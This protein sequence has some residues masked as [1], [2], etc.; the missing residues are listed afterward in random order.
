MHTSIFILIITSTQHYPAIIRPL[1]VLHRSR[2]RWRAVTCLVWLVA[3]LLTLPTVILIDL[4]TSHCDGLTESGSCSQ[5]CWNHSLS[6][7][8]GPAYDLQHRARF[9]PFWLWQLFSI[10]W[11]E[12]GNRGGTTVTSITFLVTCLAYGNNCLKPFLYTLLSKPYS[13]APGGPGEDGCSLGEAGA[14][15]AHR[16]AVGLSPSAGARG[17]AAACMRP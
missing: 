6:Q 3:F 4:R 17:T 14:R 8:E 15:V 13:P 12:Q 10:Y 9:L 11:Y 16:R 1:D 2:D 7:A 5:H